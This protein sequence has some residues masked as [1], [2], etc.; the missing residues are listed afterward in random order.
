MP[1]KSMVM[2]IRTK[3]VFPPI[4]SRD[5]DWC[6]YDDNTYGGGPGEPIGWGETEQA[7]IADLVEK[8]EN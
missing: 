2:K 6:A 8:L 3:N 4:P 1:Q 5:F 7:A